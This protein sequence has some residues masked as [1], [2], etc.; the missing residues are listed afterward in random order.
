MKKI[1]LDNAATTPVDKDVIEVMSPYFTDIYG[2][3]S[4][5]HSFGQ[6]AKGAIEKAR[7]ILAAYMGADPTEIIF[8]GSGTESNNL[9]I[10]GASLYFGKEKDHIIT[11]SIAHPSVLETV[12]FLE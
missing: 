8:L 12:F 2:N 3:P 4:S 1:Y 5:T 9:A 7:S 11:S 10:K 6:E